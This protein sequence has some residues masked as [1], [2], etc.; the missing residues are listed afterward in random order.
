MLEGKFVALGVTGSI[1]AYKAVEL[2]RLLKKR[3]ARVQVV[4]TKAAQEFVTPLTF[5]VVS[6]N[7][8][9]TDMFAEPTSWEVGHVALA[10][11]A[12]LFLVAPATADTIA[13]IAAGMAN[14]MLTSTILA[15]RSPKMIVPAMNVH[16]F[17]NPITQ[18][19]IKTLRELGFTVMEPDEGFLACGYTGKGRF[20]DPKEIVQQVELLLEEKKDLCG[21]VVL[22][23]AGPTREP[24]DPVRFITNHS[25]G[26]MGYSIAQRAAARGAKVILISGPTNLTPPRGLYKYIPVNTA[27]EMRD[28]V[29]EYFDES[30]VTIKAAAVADF[31]PK[32]YKSEKIKKQQGKLA[33]ELERNPDILLELGK[34]K[35]RQVL[36]GFAAE[37]TDIESNALSKLKNKNLD[38]IVANDLKQKGAGFGTDTNIV[39]IIHRDGEKEVLPQ[40]LKSEVADAILDKVV[41]YLS[42]LS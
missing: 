11:K 10:D 27:V 40:M 3:G 1:A 29:L 2:T 22:I 9:I 6:Q 28:A 38:F 31:R 13:R 5:R 42:N 12:D 33:L 32:D 8:V 34:R 24:I 4:M 23:T 25:S 39:K 20:P 18:K 30:D 37:T 15:T 21:K 36:V 16:M 35:K 7:P 14:D 17:E 19:N 26:K 41:S